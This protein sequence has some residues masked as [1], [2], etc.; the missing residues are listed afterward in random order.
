MFAAS[1]ETTLRRLKKD[2]HSN[3]HVPSMSYNLNRNTVCQD[4]TG[5]HSFQIISR[6]PTSPSVVDRESYG[7]WL[8]PLGGC[9]HFDCMDCG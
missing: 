8:R 6:I 9:H 2:R 5:V 7:H 4:S 1:T 3:L